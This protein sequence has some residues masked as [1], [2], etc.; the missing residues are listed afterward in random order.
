M[1]WRK[2]LRTLFESAQQLQSLENPVFSRD[3]SYSSIEIRPHPFFTFL[4]ERMRSVL[5]QKSWQ[6]THE[7][8]WLFQRFGGSSSPRRQRR[9]FLKSPCEAIGRRFTTSR[10]SSMR[11]HR[12]SNYPKKAV[13]NTLRD[14]HG[15][16]TVIQFFYRSLIWSVIALVCCFHFKSMEVFV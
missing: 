1:T 10:D 2:T 15:Q 16:I 11:R 8:A 3:F 4:R 12:W 13:T 9:A 5:W 14:H 7:K 6:W